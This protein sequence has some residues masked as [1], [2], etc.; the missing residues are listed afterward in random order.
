[1]GAFFVAASYMRRLAGLFCAY[2]A[3]NNSA[4]LFLSLLRGQL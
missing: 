3:E 4:S 2:F 1:M